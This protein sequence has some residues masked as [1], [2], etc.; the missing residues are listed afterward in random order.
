MKL[1]CLALLL[2]LV[3]SSC[4]SKK[5]IWYLQDAAENNKTE[6]NYQL[7][8]IQ[9]NDILKIDV[10]TL[11]PE[12]AVPYKQ[13]GE[14]T[15]QLGNV[16]LLQ[17]QG[18]LVSQNGTINFPVLGEIELMN[19]S[20]LD[21][22]KQIQKLLVDGG[23]LKDPRVTVR[24]VN[25]KVTVLGEVLNP[26]TFTFTEQN[27]TILQ[28]LGYAGDLTINGKRDDVLV[29]REVDGVRTI[30]HIDLT[31][32]EFMNSEFYYVRPNDVIIVNQNPPRVSASGYIGDV[33][34]LLAFSTLILSTIILLQR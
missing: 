16:Q 7:N 33:G 1:K 9:P 3:V 32:T 15:T 18:Y 17:L 14:N 13:G 27:I 24:I 28:A 11:V 20:T 23:H 21:A 4:A 12:A 34:T 30:T 25:A 8:T 6:I 5:E 19:L 31:S 29:T 26:G 10:E 22:E 2:I